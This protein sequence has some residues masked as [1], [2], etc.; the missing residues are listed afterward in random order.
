MIG[1]VLVMFLAL[2]VAAPASALELKAQL[3]EQD[4]LDLKSLYASNEREKLIINGGR[5]SSGKAAAEV[6]GPIRE[7]AIG[8]CFAKFFVT[9]G[10]IVEDRVQW[11]EVEYHEVKTRVWIKPER[12]DRPC[13]EMTTHQNITLGSPI[14]E[15]TLV[16]RYEA[17]V[18]LAFEAS[19]LVD[20]SISPSQLENAYLIEIS[21]SDFSVHDTSTYE[22]RFEISRRKGI[23]ANVVTDEDGNFSVHKAHNIIFEAFR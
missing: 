10:E 22:L 19:S 6:Y 7:T 23:S 2:S 9:V 8:T 20:F 18:A 12:R 5:Y 17:R 3:T 13:S 4:L 14:E 16:R 11:A 21:V 15:R 1:L